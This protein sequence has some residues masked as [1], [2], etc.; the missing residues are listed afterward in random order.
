MFSRN[1]SSEVPQR[2]SPRAVR[3]LKPTA[4]E[5]EAVSSPNPGGPSKQKSPKVAERRSPRSPVS[6][7]Y[8]VENIIHIRGHC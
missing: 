6:E 3:Q 8:K 7:V 1:G 5:T 4:L 2:V